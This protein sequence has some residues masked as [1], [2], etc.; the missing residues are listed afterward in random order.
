MSLIDVSITS[1]VDKN[2]VTGEMTAR[3]SVVN[4]TAT[5]VDHK[6]VLPCKGV[7][8]STV[9]DDTSGNGN[10]AAAFGNAQVDTEQQDPFFLNNGVL[11]LDGDGDY[12]TVPN[13]IDFNVGSGDFTWEFMV[14][15]NAINTSGDGFETFLFDL[16]VNHPFLLDYK[17][18]TN[19]LRFTL[20]GLATSISVL[21]SF[22]PVLGQFYHF[23][24]VRHGNIMKVFID[25]FLQATT[26]AFSQT[27]KSLDGDLIIGALTPTTR[28]LDGKI[29]DIRFTKGL[30]RYIDCFL[31]RLPQATSA[32]SHELLTIAMDRTFN[33]GD[34][35]FMT[36]RKVV[37]GTEV[38]L[39]VNIDGAGFGSPI[40]VNPV[41][42][43]GLIGV[44]QFE[45]GTEFAP[46]NNAILKLETN[47][48][49]PDV[50]IEISSS[51]IDGITLIEDVPFQLP[52]E[53]ID[54][55]KTVEVIE[56]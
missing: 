54:I 7:D 18:T 20:A 25:R 28:E 26:G 3:G 43:A 36:D 22:T 8:E 4:G 49:S 51:W 1:L 56:L 40:N 32:K 12:L 39:R 27:V 38:K 17:N 6:L 15:W 53:V 14:L 24:F 23:A 37:A 16:G 44:Y 35:R 30:A 33:S 19:E 2:T 10:N 47:S 41:P 45:A 46:E 55:T 5:D 29:A 52:L 31:F 42:V 21:N 9:F 48:P 11:S 13:S 34:V 50:Q